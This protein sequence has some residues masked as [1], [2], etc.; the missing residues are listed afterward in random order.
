MKYYRDIDYFIYFEE[1]PHMGIPGVIIANSDGTANI[2]INTLYSR[3]RQ[4]DTIRHELRHLVRQHQ[5]CD[6]MTVA[7]KE[8]EADDTENPAYVFGDNFSSV[9]YIEIFKKKKTDRSSRKRSRLPNVFVELPSNMIPMFS[10]LNVFKDYM[11]AMQEQY[12]REKA[13][14]STS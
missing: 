14:R 9:E 3:K 5:Y 13:E 12:Q 4:Q 8:Q 1:F 7:D 2:F 10:S 6:W 11:F